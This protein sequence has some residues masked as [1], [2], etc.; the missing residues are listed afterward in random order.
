MGTTS[1]VQWARTTHVKLVVY[2]GLS[3]VD[4]V[5]NVDHD[6]LWNIEICIKVCNKGIIRGRLKGGL[7]PNA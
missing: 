4:F 7:K 1:R 3:Y 2:I 5:G 6:V